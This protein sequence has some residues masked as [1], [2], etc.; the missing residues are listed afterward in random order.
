MGDTTGIIY[1]NVMNDFSIGNF[2]DMSGLSPNQLNEIEPGK[3][4]FV[5]RLKWNVFFK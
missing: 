1:N 3:N 4:T 5:S 2:S